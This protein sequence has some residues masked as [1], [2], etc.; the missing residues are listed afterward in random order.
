[1]SEFITRE[2]AAKSYVS[3]FDEVAPLPPPPYVE[4]QS[5][6]AVVEHNLGFVLTVANLLVTAILI[7]GM[8]INGSQVQSAIIVGGLYF[9]TTTTAFVF[10]ITGALTAMVNGWQREKTERLRVEAYRELGGLNLE[11]RLSVEETRQME[12]AGRRPPAEGVQ[13]VSPLNSYVPAIAEGEEA[14]AE[15]IRFAMGLYTTLGKPD[16]KRVH[17]DG[18]L[19]IRM[20]GSKRGSGSRDAG[21]WLLRE[22]IVERVKGGY[23][24]KVETYPTRESLRHLL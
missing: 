5:Q 12:L 6:P 20:I 17:P 4:V 15:G 24:L 23:R 7:T 1:M 8:L 10:V 2:R 9:A 14:Q 16:P 19:T 13:R 21:R 18:R 11:W 22:G 3:T